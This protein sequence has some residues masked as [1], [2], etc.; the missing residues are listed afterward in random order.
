MSRSACLV[1]VVVMMTMAIAG[2][3]GDNPRPPPAGTTMLI[4]TDPSGVP[5]TRLELPLIRVGDP[6]RAS[7]VIRNVGDTASGAI[8]V[9]LDGTNGAGLAIDGPGTTCIAASLAPAASCTIALVFDAVASGD[10]AAILTVASPAGGTLEL[11][12]I[13]HAGAPELQLDAAL[14]FDKVE[15]GIG[16]RRSVTVHNDG[17]FPA[18]I[19]AIT[20]ANGLLNPDVFSQAATTCGASLDPRATCTVD[21]EARPSETLFAA[22][23]T[24]SVTS[25]GTRHSAALSARGAHRVKVVLA[26]SGTVTMTE[27]AGAQPVTQIC[28]NDC[29]LLTSE[30]ISLTETPDA[31]GQFLGWSVPEDGGLCGSHPTCS[32]ITDRVPTIVAATWL[33]AG[34]ISLHVA[35]AHGYGT[36][37]VVSAGVTTTCVVECTLSVSAGSVD[38]AVDGT[39]PAVGFTGACTSSG[40]RCSY[41]QGA[42][43]SEVTIT[44]NE[45]PRA[46]WTYLTGNGSA[47]HAVAFDGS[48]NLIIATQ[49][50]VTKLDSSGVRLWS[51]TFFNLVAD[52]TTGPDDT[53]LVVTDSLV[54]KLDREGLTTGLLMDWTGGCSGAGGNGFVHCIAA[55]PSS[56]A[57]AVNGGLMIARWDSDGTRR[58]LLEAGTQGGGIGF[59]E[60]DNV[61]IPSHQ[62]MLMAPLDARRFE[63]FGA[64]LSTLMNLAPVSAFYALAS[65]TSGG[66]HVFA[67]GTTNGF[68]GLA[69]NGPGQVAHALFDIIGGGWTVDGISLPFSYGIFAS[70]MA[71]SNTGR[72]AVVGTFVSGS[73]AGYNGGWVQI[74]E[75]HSVAVAPRPFP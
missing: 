39:T 52:V 2:C 31:D 36:I 63:R 61:V 22:T 71:L 34:S 48:G 23:A 1:A 18:P 29:E 8:A 14:A 57:V 19:D 56:G 11:A 32:I 12:I 54:I 55:S 33:P 24:L 7:V 5:L 66:I 6:G 68:V 15:I 43:R 10:L 65:D 53:I 60:Q 42:G 62:S 69:V 44:L 46:S 28:G 64:E 9:S 26:G 13:A 58:F 50:G 73:I 40:A 41:R 21:I 75:P 25:N 20:L 17:A 59:D 51:R 27:L 49:T 3:G 67:R 30:A 4:A 37:Q 72:L 74:Y 70:N 38:V 35:I 45:D 16:A 47:V